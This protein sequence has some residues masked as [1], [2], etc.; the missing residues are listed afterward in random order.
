[1]LDDSK[2]ALDV[3]I[4]AVTEEQGVDRRLFVKAGAG[5]LATGYALT[6]LPVSAQ[7]ITT[8][9]QGIEGGEISVPSPK[10]AIRGYAAMPAGKKGPFPVVLVISEIWAVH[11]WVQDMCRRYAKTGY[12]AVAV[13]HFQRYGDVGKM[14]DI[15]EILK[16]VSAVPDADVVQDLDAALAWAKASGKGN[17]N[18]AAVTGFC[19]G[20]RQTWLYALHN[21]KLKAAMPFYGQVK[22]P[23]TNER[24]TKNVIDH[25]AGLKVPVMGFYG[26]ADT[27]IATAPVLQTFN[28]LQTTGGKGDVVI[29]PDTPHAFMADYRPSYR[30]EPAE[31]AWKKALA[32]LKAN[33]VA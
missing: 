22:M 32:F 9:M 27:G 16:V 24:Q 15:Q 3:Q 13:D 30:K 21:P 5:L 33:G 11:A 7:T 23:S 19:W 8:D 20:G 6:V 14:S 31:D 25:V 10:G 28:L 26:G 18:K 12:M 1:M 2:L 29:Y 4:D 17:V